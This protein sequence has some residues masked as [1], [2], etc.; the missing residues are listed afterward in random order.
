MKSEGL[1]ILEV[2]TKPEDSS[3]V[4]TSCCSTDRSRSLGLSCMVAQ[5]YTTAVLTF[6]P[7]V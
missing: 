2:S 6:F 5:V 3:A 4:Y 7:S 1:L